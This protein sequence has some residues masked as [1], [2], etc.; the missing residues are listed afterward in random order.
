MY[1]NNG[2]SIIGW[3]ELAVSSRWQ[4]AIAAVHPI[5]L[6]QHQPCCGVTVD[7]R[8]LC[9]SDGALTLFDSISAATRFLNLLNVERIAKGGRR[10][11]VI[12]EQKTLQC[13][14]LG[15]KGITAC[16]KCLARD[17]AHS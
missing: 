13:F 1:A 9:G 11:C 15:A 8:W 7:Q 2:Q 3:L 17:G 14:Q 4:G 12:A 10:D 6:D 16:N 5:D